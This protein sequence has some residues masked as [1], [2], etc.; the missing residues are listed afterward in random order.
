VNLPEFRPEG[1]EC[2]DLLGRLHAAGRFN[3]AADC[4]RGL[5]LDRWLD[6]PGFARVLEACTENS[7]EVF[8]K[9]PVRSSTPEL[10]G[11]DGN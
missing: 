5:T 8:W 9:G 7:I 11:C 2:V 6:A 4:Q 3:Y 1:L 10:D